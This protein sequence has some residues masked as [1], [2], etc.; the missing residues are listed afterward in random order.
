MLQNGNKPAVVLSKTNVK[1]INNR[2]LSWLAF[3][4]RVLQEA[5]DKSVPLLQRLRF[6]GIFSNNQDEFI[7]VRLANITRLS[8]LKGK[9]VPK[10][11]G[12]YTARELLA[13]LN[14]R[15]LESQILFTRTYNDILDEMLL[16]NIYVVNETQLSEEQ[17][18]FCREY[19]SSIISPRIVPLILRKTTPMPFLNDGKIYHIVKMHSGG[20]KNIHY[21]II[22]IPVS[23]ACPRFIVLPSAKGT[24]NIVFIDDI[25][26]LCLDEIFF[27]FNYDEISAYT[28]KIVRDACFT[29]DDDVSKS[30]IEKMEEGLDNR[31]RGRAVRL[32]YDREMP[33]DVLDFIARKLN[34]KASE[35]L[36]AGG[37]YHL[38][39]DLMK[40]P[41]ICPELENYNP[42]PI[43]HPDIKPSFS[44]LQTI[45]T[46]DILLYYPYHT[47][48]HFLDFLREAAIDPKV[49]RIY[50]TLYR[51]AEHSKVIN[52]LINAAKNGK[53]VVVM[54]ELKARFDEEQNVENSDALQR[55]GVKVIHGIEAIKVHC[56][57]V[58]IERKEK[59]RLKGYVYVGT[60]NFNESTALIYSDFGFFTSDEQIVADTQRVFEFLQNTHKRFSCGQLMVSPYYMRSQF[61]ELI[62]Q[63][64]KFAKKGRKAFI[65]AKFNSLTDEKMV[66]LLYKASKAGVQIRLIIRGACCLCPQVKGIS[67]NIRVISI[68]DKYLEH[69]RMV[70]F[71]HNGED[72]TF[73]LSADWMT[74][75]LD[76]RVEVGVPIQNKDIKKT[77][78]EIF[79]LQWSDNVKARDLSRSC[80]PNYVQC[81][82]GDI[83]VRSQTALCDYFLESTNNK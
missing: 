9:N 42:K 59:A 33:Q 27:M 60:G 64:I 80:Q 12:S 19:F 75:N 53:Q 56:K 39:R 1:V 55:A 74:R 5:Q 29:L 76:R 8:Y 51:T 73:I 34:F 14:K 62:E 70:I 2:E 58:F 37:R 3:N 11:T 38:M 48:N 54:L 16:H 49:E 30:L 26:R 61:E 46:K 71:H 41:K 6:L 22:Q 17:K 52:T 63:E 44:I 20:N 78:K 21:A 15:M 45:K 25:I 47:F 50:I 79:K 69:S 13:L 10:L 4:E 18:F 65:Y 7:K 82:N 31:Q 67:D 35:G 77:L 68:I 36:E 43:L 23:T 66:R 32:V 57:I 72:K 40:F 28:F 24:I 81:K 83:P